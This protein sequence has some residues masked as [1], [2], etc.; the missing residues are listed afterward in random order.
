MSM[1]AL[2]L[3]NKLEKEIEVDLCWGWRGL[4]EKRWFWRGL[5]LGINESILGV[6]GG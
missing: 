2:S 4:K 1:W 5:C 3:M 6:L